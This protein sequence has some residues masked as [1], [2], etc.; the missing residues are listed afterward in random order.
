MRQGAV[1][2]YRPLNVL[3][4]VDD[5]TWECPAI[6]V[7]NSLGGIAS[8]ARAG[9]DRPRKRGLPEAMVLDNGPEFRGSALAGLERG[10]RG[11]GGHPARQS[12][13]ER[14]GRRLQRPV[15]G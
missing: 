13:A 12:R 4:I 7:D 15:A 11:A 10:A 5:C 9:S 6:E 14:L 8:V 2:S 1:I 3:T